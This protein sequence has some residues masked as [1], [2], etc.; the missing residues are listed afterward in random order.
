MKP[1]YTAW[2][3]QVCKLIHSGACAM[4]SFSNL[5]VSFKAVHHI[6]IMTELRWDHVIPK[7]TEH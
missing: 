4:D 6:S 5:L 7:F 3:I 2:A 1:P